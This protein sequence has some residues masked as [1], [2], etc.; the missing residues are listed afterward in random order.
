MQNSTKLLLVKTAHTI[1]WAFLVSVIAFVFYSGVTGRIS[2]EV[3]IAVGLVGFEGILLMMN[4]GKC[5]LTSVA[6]H[7]TDRQEDNF[8][9]LL[10]EWLARNN[11]IIFT[12]IFFIGVG[13]VV[14]RVVQ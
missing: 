8:D 1:I 9:I 6:R 7:Y 5:P 10:P 11:K 14:Y 3:W 12:V 2:S 4:R 13:L